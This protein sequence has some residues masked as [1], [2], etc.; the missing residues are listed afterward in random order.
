MT[1]DNPPPAPGASGAFARINRYRRTWGAIIYLVALPL[2]F[3]REMLLAMWMAGPS[4]AWDG[5]GFYG[6]GLIYDRTIFP[7]T[8]GWT[9]AHFGGMPFPNFYPPLFFWLVSLLHHTR[10]FSYDAA[11]KLLVMIPVLLMPA[12]VWLLAW[13][14]S[15][16]DQRVAFWAGLLSLVPLLSSRFGGHFQW[17]SGLDYFS[18]FAVGMYSQP[19]GFVLLIVWYVVYLK[20]AGRA[21]RGILSCLLL[22]LAVL[23][24]Y[25]NGVTAVLLVGATATVD[26]LQYQRTPTGEVQ[27]RQAAR[28]KLLGHLLSP[29]V[30]AG[31]ALFWLAP[32]LSSY[33]YFVTRPF[34]LVIF[35]RGMM[36]WYFVAL[37][38]MIFWLRRKAAQVWPFII[39]CFILAFILIFSAQVAPRWYPIQA[40]RFS[41]ILNFFLA[42]PVAYALTITLAKLKDVVGQRIP[43]LRPWAGKLA[44]YALAILL[45]LPVLALYRASRSINAK[46][47]FQ[48]QAS[49][50]FY[51][52]V[53]SSETNTA[54]QLTPPQGRT[55]DYSSA[56]E[57]AKPTSVQPK[58]L[59]EMYK[60]EHKDDV[61]VATMAALTVDSILRF[62]QQHRDGRYAVELAPLYS[63]DFVA[64]D[65]H[66]LNSYLGA[67]GNETLN[68]IFREASANAL[69]MYPQVNALSYNPDNFG[70]SS[71]LADDI[72]FAEQP[73]AKHLERARML[74][75]KY[76]VVYSAKI[77]EKMAA[78]P[79]IKNRYDF[80]A[81][82]IF[83][84]QH[85]PPPP[86][87]AL[88]YRPALLVS[89][90]TVKGRYAN[91]Y[92][93]I[94]LAEE[95][96]F[97]GWF[98]VLLVRSPVKQLDELGSSS[99]LKQFGALILDTYDCDRCD[100]VYYQLKEFS[101]SRPLILFADDNSLFNR[102]KNSMDEFPLAQVIERQPGGA[103]KWLDNSGPTRRYGTSAIR[104]QWG[105]IRQTLENHKIPTEAPVVGGQITQN[106]IDINYDSSVTGAQEPAI[107]VLVS[108]TYHPNWQAQRGELI[109]AANPMYMLV[110]VRHSTHL[111]F[112]RRQIDRVG[113]WA[114]VATLIGLLGFTVWCYSPA[115]RRVKLSRPRVTRLDAER[116]P[117]DDP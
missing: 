85:D 10:L 28:H 77:K 61:E 54:T 12:A 108:T 50:A 63:P 71:V 53:K 58:V 55:T 45:L 30:A 91:E 99:E 116:E 70:F 106:R 36:V 86:V 32:M 2:I 90:F 35:T 104:R 109:Y 73:L 8:F 110:F 100:L 49:M 5:T 60:Q 115:L 101:K 113:L 9:Q 92:N 107:P 79:E 27:Q 57:S 81:W 34:T 64:F 22:A 84:L 95:Q 3:V 76:F 43:V 19:L 87:R 17:A 4:R 37:F 68:V 62:A 25:L 39:T 47:V 48:S 98:D 18:T 21:W 112:A 7:D 103:G 75:A 89:N 66:A 102:I 117:D 67:Q 40:N 72:D 114:S 94:R 46:L 1:T 11:F 15:N 88:E 93:Y 13:T 29:V 78:E 33:N 69:F 80:G 74:G 23:A 42:V 38:G 111:I 56:V 31:L 52:P 20:S 51:P 59:V 16:R 82:S 6:I 24:N 65:S 96:F 14:L 105:Q 97:D 41:P 83:E 44:P 26:L